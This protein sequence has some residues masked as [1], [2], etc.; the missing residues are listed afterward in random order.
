MGSVLES[1]PRRRPSIAGAGNF[2]NWAGGRDATVA[3]KALSLAGRS[4][5]A[6]DSPAMAYCPIAFKFT[7]F[8]EPQRREQPEAGGRPLVES[9]RNLATSSDYKLSTSRALSAGKCWSMG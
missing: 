6:S 3:T 1:C 2:E 8:P 4:C 5:Q 9:V 7:E